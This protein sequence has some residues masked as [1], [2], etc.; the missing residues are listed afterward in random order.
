LAK[1]T[2]TTK[3]TNKLCPSNVGERLIA[4]H[5]V[6]FF[7]FSVLPTRPPHQFAGACQACVTGALTILLVA[8]VCSTH[9]ALVVPYQLAGDYV[10]PNYDQCSC[11]C[12]DR[13]F[14]GSYYPHAVYRGP[15]KSIFFNVDGEALKILVLTL[16][17]VL[18]LHHCLCHL[19][20]LHQNQMLRRLALIPLVCSIYPHYYGWWSFFNYY[21]DRFYRQYFHQAVFSITEAASTGAWLRLANS[22]LPPQS[23]DQCCIVV[24]TVAIY[25][26]VQNS[27]DN[28]V[29]NLMHR[30]LPHQIQRDVG[31]TITDIV[32]LVLVWSISTQHRLRWLVVVTTILCLGT[33]LMPN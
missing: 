17:Y 23:A 32:P 6:A 22:K 8:L 21:N 25:H 3:T 18:L 9:L 13:L 2:A 29:R 15:A 24:A 10:P 19:V 16:T 11:E 26:L 27:I 12:W 30:G 7:M 14:K 5:H 1:A 31:M 28:M 33:T 20:Q 4:H